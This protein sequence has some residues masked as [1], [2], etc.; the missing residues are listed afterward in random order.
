MCYRGQL[1]TAAFTFF[2]SGEET[3]PQVPEQQKEY[4]GK[5]LLS[6]PS[7]AVLHCLLEILPK[8]SRL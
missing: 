7:S 4:G 8:A 6:S 5:F 2:L 3:V 1:S